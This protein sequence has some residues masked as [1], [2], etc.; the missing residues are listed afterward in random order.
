MKITNRFSRI[1]IITA[2]VSSAIMALLFSVITIQRMTLDYNENGVHFDEESVTTYDS[3]SIIAYTGLA[4]IFV[5]VT[6]LLLI[7]VKKLFSK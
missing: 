4:I 1:I 3:G 7:V 5:T 6:T 2:T